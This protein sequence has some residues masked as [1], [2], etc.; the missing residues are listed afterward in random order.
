MVIICG[1]HKEISC[2][3]LKTIFGDRM[4][5]FQDKKPIKSQEIFS[6]CETCFESRGLHFEI[7]L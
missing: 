7:Y 5:M 4:K 2:M 1:G 3:N 6:M